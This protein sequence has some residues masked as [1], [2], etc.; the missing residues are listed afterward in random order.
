MSLIRLEKVSKYYKSAETVSV[1]MT[2]VSLNFDIGE[3]VAITGESGAGKSTL[4]NVISGLDKYEEGE[5]FL[6]NEET[7]HYTIRDWEQFR[8]AYIGFVFQDYNIIDSYTVLQNV[9]LALEV[10]GFDRKKRKARALELIDRVGL[11]SHKH[12]KASKLSGGQKQRCVIARAL[13][14]DCPIIVA[15]EPTG[16]LDSKSGDQV[17]N[18]LHEVSKDKLVIIVTHEFDHVESFVTR[19]ITMHDGEV[20]EDKKY[21]KVE[22]TSTNDMPPIKNMSFGLLMKFALRNLLSTPKKL[23]FLMLMQIIVVAVFTLVYTN[24]ISA[25]REVGL[26]SAQTDVFPSVPETRVLVEKRDGS[27]FT[28][29]EINDINRNRYVNEVYENG[30]N[31][32]N[33]QNLYYGFTEGNY[34]SH[35]YIAGS[36][37]A[38]SLISSDVDGELPQAINEIVITSNIYGDFQIGDT[39]D[40]YTGPAT[41]YYGYGYDVEP[42][43]YSGSSYEYFQTFTISGFDKLN[44]DFIYFSEAFLN[45][46]YPIV[47]NPNLDQSAYQRMLEIVANNI[48]TTIDTTT[49]FYISEAYDDTYE[50]M[51][52]SYGDVSTSYELEEVDLDFTFQHEE[53]GLYTVSLTDIELYRPTEFGID[54][55][56]YL[57]TSIYTDMLE[58]IVSQYESYYISD[59]PRSIL[60]VSVDGY[61]NGTR[62]VET[63]DQN[64]YKVYY[65]ANLAEPL[66][67][68]FVFLY[69]V[70]AILLLGIFGLF[71]Y[72]IVHAV[73]KNVMAAR[74]RD[75][76]IFRSVG[77]SQATLGRLVVI[78]Q[79]I[80]NIAAFLITVIGI[81]ILSANVSLI[82][83]E[84]TY[85]EFKDYAILLVAFA[86]FGMWLGLRFNKKVFKQ[87]VIETL[88]SSKGG[89]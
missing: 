3:F 85:M 5:Y 73:T 53:Y 81:Q 36:D 75:F 52:D 42:G 79:I 76:A 35:T 45:Q 10:Q 14:K 43:M 1:G 51:I 66:R 41:Y 25:I 84:L 24:Q 31:F 27:L 15:D 2:N 70:I 16:N 32:L 88:T 62:F 57:R 61:H 46:A 83:A 23:I 58:D 77:T 22:K 12:H 13:A 38:N 37:T 4:L 7:S 8:G 50:A 82:R 65:P 78:E 56:L 68:F 59:V 29:D 49:I 80:M 9:L 67:D 47:V 21:Q 86:L 6:N 44:R 69:S 18:L 87:T 89:E 63:I 20:M 55:Y 30:L 60:S 33:D 26:D 19:K 48:T 34:T 72:S 74:K 28:D 71:L 64:T 39:I 40:L 11:T 17:L 54:N